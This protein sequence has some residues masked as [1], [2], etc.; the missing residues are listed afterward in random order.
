MVSEGALGRLVMGERSWP[1]GYGIMGA[2][3]FLAYS[4]FSNG[5]LDMFIGGIWR[6]RVIASTET[7]L[8]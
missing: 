8:A 3:K 4:T 7:C 6:A 1:G 5:I 2:I